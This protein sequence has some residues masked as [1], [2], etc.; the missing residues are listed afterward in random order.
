MHTRDPESHNR[1]RAKTWDHFSFTLPTR[2]SPSFRPNR[3]DILPG[4]WSI[5]VVWRIWELRRL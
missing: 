1:G 5:L 2:Y 4:C 3:V